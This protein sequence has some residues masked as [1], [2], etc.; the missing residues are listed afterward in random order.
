[1]ILNKTMS[2]TTHINTTISKASKTLNF[3][4]RNLSSCLKSTKESAYLSLVRSTLEYACSVWDPY[5][6]VHITSIEK[7]KEEWP[8][9]YFMIIADTAVYYQCYINCDGHPWRIDE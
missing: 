1:M 2:F 8:V 9:G 5:Q 6:T 3:V 4:K 7:S